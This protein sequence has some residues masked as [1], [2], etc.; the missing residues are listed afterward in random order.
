[1][2]AQETFGPVAAVL[3]ARDAAE[4]VAIAN[5]SP[6][7][8]SAMLWT[9]PERGQKMARELDVG[10]VFINSVT[11]SDPRLPVGGVKLSGYGRELGRMGMLDLCNAQTV[12]V[13]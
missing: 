4:A 10:G 3:S 7:G 1:V 9:S 11:M 12:W 2:V 5:D 13:A 6:Y 8:L